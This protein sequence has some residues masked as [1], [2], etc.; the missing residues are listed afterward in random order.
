MTSLIGIQARLQAWFKC[1][2]AHQRS[3]NPWEVGIRA[4]LQACVK[5]STAHHRSTKQCEVGIRA[6]LQ[7][8]IACSAAHHRSTKPWEVGIRARLQAWITCSTAHHGSTRICA[9]GVLPFPILMQITSSPPRAAQIKPLRW[10]LI[11]ETGA[12]WQPVHPDSAKLTM[13]YSNPTLLYTSVRTVKPTHHA[14]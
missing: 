14:L 12:P 11:V 3:T 6:R 5:C 8:C 10:T 7:T 13:L 1:S 2:K 9:S 4:R